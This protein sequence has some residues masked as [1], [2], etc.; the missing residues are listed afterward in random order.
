MV[1]LGLARTCDIWHIY[2]SVALCTL[3]VAKEEEKKVY[4]NQSFSN[5]NE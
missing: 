4:T 3:H 2:F 5:E 1:V